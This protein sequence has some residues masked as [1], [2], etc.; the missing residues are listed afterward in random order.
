MKQ[1]KYDEPEKFERKKIRKK[2]KPMTEEQRLAAAERLAKARSAKKPAAMTSIHESIR[3]LPEEHAL[4]P[5]K[6]KQWIK[7]WKSKLQS[8]RHY[9]N[10]KEKGF[11]GEYYS[12]QAYITNMQNYLTN[13][14]WSDLYYGE[15]RE[16]RCSYVCVAMAYDKDGMPKRT[17]NTWYTDIG[18]YMGEGVD[19]ST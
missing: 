15:R 3:D 13:G 19:V 17:M 4:H 16:N 1:K 18:L 12:T 2:R 7:D 11:V 9:R 8:I 10:S 14:V 6:V 5:A